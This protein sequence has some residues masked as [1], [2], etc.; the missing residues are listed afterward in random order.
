M[1]SNAENIEN[2]VGQ[3]YE[4]GFYTDIEQEMLPPGLNEAT[5][6]F[7]SAKKNEP[8]WLLEWRLKCYQ[9]FLSMTEPVWANVTYPSIDLQA[10]SYYAAPKRDEDRPKSLDE[11]DPKILETYEKL[12]IPLQEQ[13]VL[14]LLYTYDAADDQLCLILGVRSNLKK[15]H[16]REQCKDNHR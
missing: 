16:K 15:K 6:R 1:A 11:I 3:S 8:E 12:G 13:K 5:I 2:L 4:A 14:C 7:I 9:Q 10:I